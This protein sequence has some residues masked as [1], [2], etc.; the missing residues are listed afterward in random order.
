[1]GD[2]VVEP[3]PPSDQDVAMLLPR[4]PLHRVSRKGGVSVETWCAALVSV[5]LGLKAHGALAPHASTP[6]PP[7]EQHRRKIQEHIKFLR[8][9]HLFTT[10]CNL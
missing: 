3:D 9:L 4:S 6:Q 10:P 2:E 7:Q 5:D 8:K 1:M